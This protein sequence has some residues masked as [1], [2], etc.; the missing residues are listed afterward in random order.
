MS[1]TAFTHLLAVVLGLVVAAWWCRSCRPGTAGCPEIVATTSTVQYIHDTVTHFLP[2]TGGSKTITR[3]PALPRTAVP[4]PTDQPDSCCRLI[5]EQRAETTTYADS[6][7]SIAIQD[8]VGLNR[9]LGRS[10]SYRLLKPTTIVHTTNNVLQPPSAWRVLAG[11]AVD[12]R[13]HLAAV[14][15]VQYQRLQV[16]LAAGTGQVQAGVLYQ[17]R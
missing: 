3:L 10:I 16:Q 4:V 8:T 15:A 5:A 14:G 2:A 17:L 7:I 9:I 1:K 11:A 12:Q 6:N 13:G